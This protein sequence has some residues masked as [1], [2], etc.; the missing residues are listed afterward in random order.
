MSSRGLGV[1]VS[2]FLLLVPLTFLFLLITD[3]GFFLVSIL[4]P[5]TCFSSTFP[6]N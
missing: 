5:D 6:F 2:W 3:H 1:A 4:H